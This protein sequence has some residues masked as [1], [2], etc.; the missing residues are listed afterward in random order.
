VD[1][2]KPA[3]DLTKEQEFM[4]FYKFHT[5]V[6]SLWDDVITEVMKNDCVD[7]ESKCPPKPQYITQLQKAYNDTATPQICF[8]KCDAKWSPSSSLAE[9]DAAIPSNINCY[10]GTLQYIVDKTTEIIQK[11]QDAMSRIPSQDSF[12]DYQAIINCISDANGNAKCT[13]ANGLVYIQNKGQGQ[14]PPTQLSQSEEDQLTQQI[15][16]TNRIIGKCRVMNT[17]IPALNA[18]MKQANQNID[19]LHKIKQQAQDGTLLP[20]PAK[21]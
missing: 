5:Q 11:V 15:N 9:L 4:A 14:S 6:C 2:S 12:A 13:D 8:I 7:P 20:P 17:E 19:H 10:R 18:L 16:A 21:A 1:Y 3:V